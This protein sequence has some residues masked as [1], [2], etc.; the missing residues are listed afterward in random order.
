[1]R[2]DGSKPRLVA[3]DLDTEALPGA[4]AAVGPVWLGFYGYL[5]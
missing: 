5:R 1:M 2:T 4:A 3:D